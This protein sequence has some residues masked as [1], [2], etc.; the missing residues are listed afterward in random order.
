MAAHLRR[1]SARQLTDDSVPVAGGTHRREEYRDAGGGIMLSPGV[2]DEEFNELRDRLKLFEGKD[3]PPAKY[4]LEVQFGRDHH[5]DGR[6]M[7]GMVTAWENGTHFNGG[8]DQLLYS[9][10]GKHLQVNGCEAVIPN[11]KVGSPVIVCPTCFV[12]WK[13]EQLIGETWYR[14]P[15]QKWAEVLH[16]WFK[17]LKS[18]VD[19]K[20]K[21]NYDDIRRVS[22]AEQVK[23]LRGEALEFAR[24]AARRKS[25]VYPL[26]NIVKDTSA[27]ADL[28]K[29]LLA[30]VRG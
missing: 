26:H 29:R 5:V 2:T 3:L 7:Y 23:E 9:C 4:K 6:P 13:R 11:E 25:R 12:A 10:P 30:F 21:Y 16:G 22:G 8:G 24:S 15:P 19:I 27:G 18:D 17:R 20:I 1:G 14:L 28:E